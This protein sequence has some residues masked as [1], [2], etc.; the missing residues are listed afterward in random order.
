MN[1]PELPTVV[2]ELPKIGIVL[3]TG[4]LNAMASLALF[5]FLAV[6]KIPVA[7]MVGCIGGALACAMIGTGCTPSEV[8]E[9]GMQKL[10]KSLCALFDYS[11]LLGIFSSHL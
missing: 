10:Q 2:R 3:G 1:K 11:A 9:L 4:R 7:L 8:R 5:E 6:Q